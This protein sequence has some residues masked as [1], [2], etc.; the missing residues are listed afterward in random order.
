MHIND[1]KRSV[2]EEN[3]ENKETILKL[4][5]QYITT[6][7]KSKR[8]INVLDCCWLV[9]CCWCWVL[10]VL[11]VFLSAPDWL[12]KGNKKVTAILNKPDKHTEQPTEQEILQDQ[13]QR[14]QYQQS[15]SLI[16]QA[17]PKQSKKN[18]K[19][20]KQANQIEKVTETLKNVDIGDEAEAELDEQ[21]ELELN[22]KQAY[23]YLSFVGFWACFCVN[24]F[25]VS[26]LT[27]N[28]SKKR[29]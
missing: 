29:I 28:S 1:I 4:I 8:G 16:E 22:L 9:F 11:G 24:N 18:K 2:I 20:K 5:D 14:Q 15:A 26:L 3:S 12:K 17:P 25:V 10:G 21:V 6:Q 7:K 27:T 13:H 23:V 19:K